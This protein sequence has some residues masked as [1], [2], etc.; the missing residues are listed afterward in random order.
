LI[1][2]IA[3][4]VALGGTGYAALKL[5]KNSVGSAQIRTGAVGTSEVKD[6]SLRLKDF[7][8]GQIPAG[9][10]GATGPAGPAGTNGV[11]GHDGAPGARGPSD[12]YSG[13]D[14]TPTDNLN[15]ASVNVPAGDYAVTA[16]GQALYFRDDSTYPTI[17]GEMYCTL[18]SAG[19]AGHNT[20]AFATVPRDG[21][22]SDPQRG[23]IAT[24]SQN[25]VFHLTTADT[26]TYTCQ[27]APLGTKDGSAHMQYHNMHITAIR[28]A[29]L[30]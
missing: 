26:I 3:L 5:P 2:V 18:T 4:F 9:A 30:H 6:H 22:Q 21:F 13:S 8:T 7:R 12:A 14:T 1:S 25:S 28:V 29:A 10:R 16:S 20:G 24:M 17:D 19:D 11:N 15:T 23:G 27:N